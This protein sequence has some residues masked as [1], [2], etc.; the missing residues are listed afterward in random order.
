[1]H[2]EMICACSIAWVFQL[3]YT[4]PGIFGC[5]LFWKHKNK[6]TTSFKRFQ[7]SFAST[8]DPN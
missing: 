3:D 7:D 6:N 8:D 2:P 4:L 5:S 1:M